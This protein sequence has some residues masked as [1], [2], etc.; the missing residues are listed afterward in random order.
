MLDYDAEAPRYDETRG[1]EARARAAAD[2][3]ERMLPAATRG[4]LDVACGTGIVTARLVRPGRT[5]YGTDRS[6]GMLAVAARRL[7]GRVVRGDATALPF[8]AGSLDAVVMIWLLHLLPETGP[9]I[10]EAARVLRPGG[11]LVTTVDKN[12]GVP[13]RSASDRFDIV[14]GQAQ[15][16]GLTPAGETRF[17][18]IGQGHG[19]P[20][21]VYRLAALRSAA[22]MPATPVIPLGNGW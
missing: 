5:V 13:G 18:G 16:H 1:G 19:G 15:R 17:T 3:I 4:V 10:A 14:A 12:A 9:A 7:P 11:V 20:D 6:H 2:A 22:M 21:P 8:R